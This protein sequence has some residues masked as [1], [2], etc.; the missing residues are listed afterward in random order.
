MYS[1]K[2]HPHTIHFVIDCFEEI[3]VFVGFWLFLFSKKCRRLFN[4]EWKRS[5]TFYKSFIVLGVISTSFCA[6]VLP[7]III[8]MIY[9]ERI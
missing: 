3:A 7:I 5:C 2:I 6:V 9:L 1:A 8:Y 4:R